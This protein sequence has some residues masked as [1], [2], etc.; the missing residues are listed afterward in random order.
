MSENTAGSDSSNS[1]WPL[2]ERPGFLARRIHQIHVSLFAE[3]CAEFRVT[4]LQYSLLSELSLRCVADQS[5]LARAVSLDR[6]TTTG[7]L[8]RLEARGLVQ[9][10]T[11][12]SDRRAQACRLTPEGETLLAAMERSARRAHEAT[13][14]NLSKTDQAKLIALLKRVV[15]SHEGRQTTG[16]PEA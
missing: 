1:I 13:V 5:T 10:V 3:F 8:K 6:T 16:L 11:S 2:M 15:A 7:A 4:P 14:E 12:T 9:R